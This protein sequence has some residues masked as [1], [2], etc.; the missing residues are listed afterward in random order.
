MRILI[1]KTS[2]LGDIVQCFPVVDYLMN[3]HASAEIDWVV[4]SEFSSVVDAHPLIANVISVQTKRWRKAL[5]NINTW[6][7]ITQ[8]RKRIRQNKYDIVIDLQGNLK[9]GVFTKMARSKVKIG[10]GRKSLPEWPNLLFTNYRYNPKKELNI[11]E[12]YLSLIQ[13]YYSDFS[14]Y[15]VETSLLSVSEKEL[16]QITKILGLPVLDTANC[17]MVCP[18]ANWRNKKM[19]N[20]SM[21]EFLKLVYE[22]E[23]EPSFVFVWGSE[24]EKL[25]C[26]YLAAFFFETSVVIK[27][28]S[29]SALQNLMSR[30]KKVLAM[31]SLPLHLAGTTDTPT[32]G[33][34][35]PSSAHKYHPFGEDSKSYQGSCPY[36]KSFEKR[37]SILRTCKSGACIRDISVAKLFDSYCSY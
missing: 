15:K 19:T 21:L 32:F 25:T 13:Q 27:K 17:I 18:G 30:M 37:C 16:N 1:V 4:E 23:Q 10:F 8:V 36:G 35:G 26:E 3:K 6:K 14:T 2:S 9:S 33:I 31:D 24:E 11:R 12:E 5:L 29:L 28:L 7:Q 20:E 34:F 22:Y